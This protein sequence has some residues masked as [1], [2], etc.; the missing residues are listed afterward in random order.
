VQGGPVVQGVEVGEQLIEVARHG[1]ALPLG[2][3]DRGTVE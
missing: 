1:R 2:K 3:E